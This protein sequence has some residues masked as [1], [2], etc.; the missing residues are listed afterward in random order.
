MLSV[1][2]CTAYMV[3]PARNSKPPGQ[4]LLAGATFAGKPECIKLSRVRLHVPFQALVCPNKQS[5]K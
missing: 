3:L 2:L 4:L 5:G 1:A